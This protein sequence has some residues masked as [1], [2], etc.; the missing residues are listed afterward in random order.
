MGVEYE[1]KFAADP[2]SQQCL[3]RAIPGP[4][5]R[6]EM[7]TTYYDT[8]SGA[9]QQLRFTLRR[10][11]EN[12]RSVCTV[13]TPKEGFGRGE[14]ETECQRIEDAIPVLCK[15]GAP[16]QLA[17]L[18]REG[19]IAVCGARFTRLAAAAF[20]AD[21]TVELALDEG[22]LFAGDRRQPLCEVEVEMKTASQQAT[23]AFAQLLAARHG[24][25]PEKRSKFRRALDLAEEK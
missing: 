23:A 14:W 7:E 22:I 3:Y 5:Q 9:L 18:T 20:A 25:T 24:L 15:L 8:P 6:I 13:K 2:Q 10:R 21:G 11:L 19:L 16:E 1:L 17:S 12:G 4:W